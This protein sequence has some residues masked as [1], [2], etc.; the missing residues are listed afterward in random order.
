MKTVD[1]WLRELPMENRNKAIQNIT[2][3]IMLKG[4]KVGSLSAALKMAFWWKA[5]P[6]GHNYWKDVCNR[7]V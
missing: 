3:S 7:L 4:Y 5:S 6:E 1:Q 2:S